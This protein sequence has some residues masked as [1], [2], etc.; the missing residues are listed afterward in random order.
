MIIK[1]YCCAAFGIFGCFAG[2]VCDNSLIKMNEFLYSL[3]VTLK[4]SNIA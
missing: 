3:S 2:A 4:K 1:D